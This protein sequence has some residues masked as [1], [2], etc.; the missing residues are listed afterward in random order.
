MNNYLIFP[1]YID[2]KK[3]NIN[4]HYVNN[5]NNINNLNNISKIDNPNNQKYNVY[6]PNLYSNKFYN[7]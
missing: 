6:Y 2:N 4:N 5:I 7:N 1:Y 3:I